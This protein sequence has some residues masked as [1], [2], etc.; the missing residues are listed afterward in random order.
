[1]ITRWQS[2]LR[3]IKYGNPAWIRTKT[4]WTKTTCATITP[5]GCMDLPSMTKLQINRIYEKFHLKIKIN[6]RKMQ[7]ESYSLYLL[8][9]RIK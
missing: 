8:V 4:K 2:L 3:L 7:K 5:R 6:Q 9:H 1:M